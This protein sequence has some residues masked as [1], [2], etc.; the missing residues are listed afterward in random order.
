MAYITRD[1][2]EH[3]VIPSYRDVLAAK[4][5]SALKK[6]VLLLSQSYGEYIT[7]QKKGTSQYEVAFSPEPGYLLGESIW[8][9][10]KRPLDMVYCEAIPNTTEAILVIVKAGSVYL[11]G[12]FPL[13]N[14]SEELVIFLTQ[15]NNFEIYVYGDVPISQ[16]PEEGK[17][18]FE[19]SSVKSYTIL[20]KPIF[21]TLPLLKIY[22]LRLVEQILKEQG[23]GVLPLRKIMMSLMFIALLYGAYWYLTKPKKLIR[24]TAEANPYEEYNNI[25]LSPAPD[26]QLDQIFNAVSTLSTMPGWTPQ[27]IV[28]TKG[29]LTAQVQST[30][31]KTQTL[32]EWAKENKATINIKTNGIY[33]AMTT[34]VP[35]RDIPKKIYPLKEVIAEMV[36]RLS[37][38]Y[39]GNHITLG[40]FASK[41]VFTQVSLT[42]SID[43]V[44]PMVFVLIAK[45]LKDLPLVLQG[46]TLSVNNGNL[47]GKIIIDAL[48]SSL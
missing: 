29:T 13:E 2:G 12:S 34:A 27:K 46:A 17:F 21:P 11:D 20:E 25:L 31:S 26:Q 28:Y 35:K 33:V 32:F 1:D 16:N 15:Q 45:Q 37:N 8:H 39:P 40:E 4:Q 47:T 24:I 22:Q 9:Y 43:N 19:S 38:V 6:E 3:F 41:G 18:S 14:I 30:G 48:G 23:I 36:D 5:K 7:L 42:V 10:F 44:S